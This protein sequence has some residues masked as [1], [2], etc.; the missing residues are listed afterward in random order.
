M[1]SL[2]SADRKLLLN[3][4]SQNVLYSRGHLLFLRETTLMAQPFDPRRLVS[5]GDAFPVAE[6]IQT[7]G[8]NPPYGVFSASENGVLA[9]L[10]G[11]AAAGSQLVWFD[12]TGKQTGVLGDAARYSDLELSPDGKQASVAIQDQAPKGRDIWLYDVGR[13]LRTRFTFDQADESASIW[14]PDGSRIVFSSRRKGHLN[15]YEKASSGA[16]GEE[17]LFEDNLDKYPVSWSPDGRFVL[18]EAIGTSTGFD[19]SILPLSGDRKPIPF[20]NTKFN[21][22]GGRFSPD[23]RWIAYVSDESGKN[24]V[25]VAPFP[26]TGA[27]W[28]IS[29]G[30]G[31]SP[32]W[33]RDGSEI[34]YR[35]LGNVDRK[36]MAAA[37]NG[38]GG[39]FEAG[40]VKPLFTMRALVVA[41]AGYTYDV[42]ADGQRFLVNTPPEQTATAPIT[43]VVNWQAGLKK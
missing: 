18:Y 36:L 27:K 24:E 7:T 20:L 31:N 25:Y 42:S 30:G 43:V 28:Q 5:T 16:G 1:A 11:S 8:T 23:G 2:D 15:L 32:R 39:S 38:K 12:R 14:S 40:V 34:F 41:A 33:R 19:L 4:D 9:Y 35:T 6:Q 10:T 22:A 3:A 13:G 29:T 21:E 37:V 17:V 26:A